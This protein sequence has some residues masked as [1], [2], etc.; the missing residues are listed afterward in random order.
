MGTPLLAFCDAAFEGDRS[1]VAGLIENRLVELGEAV[2]RDVEVIPVDTVSS[3]GLRIYQRAM[4]FVLIVAAREL[5]PEAQLLID[6]SVTIGGFFCQVIGHDSFTP[7]EL[8]AIQQRMREIVAADEPIGRSQMPVEDAIAHFAA[9]GNDDKVRL[10]SGTEDCDIAVYSLRGMLDCF[11]GPMLPSTGRL[12]ECRLEDYPP[13]FILRADVE[14]HQLPLESHRDYPKLMG[15]FREYGRWLNILGIEDVGSMNQAIERGDA[16]R[17][18]LVSE[19]LHEKRISEIADAILEREEVRVVLI[20]GPSS[21]GKTTFARRLSVQLMVNSRRPLPLGLD[22][23]FVDREKTPR[24]PDGQYD[25]EALEAIDLALFNAQLQALLSGEAVSVPRFDFVEGRGVP[26]RT[27]QLSPEG[28]LLIEGIHGLNPR[29]VY[30]IPEA[31][32]FR[33]Y[34][35]ALTQLNLD[36][37]NR[38]ATTDNRLLRRMV[39]DEATRGISADETLRRWPS[40]RLGEERNIFPFQE[41]AD[42]MFNSAL[43]YEVAVLK[44]FAER[45]LYR[46]PRDVPQAVESQRLLSLLRWVRPCDPSL[47]PSNSLLREFI[48]GSVL[49]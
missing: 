32:V 45:L 49:H 29:L 42:V 41:N 40:V 25:F 44:P 3:E 5:F 31:C 9:Q 6:H 48:G 13:G 22:D 30:Q 10:F 11:H 18:I 15:V 28:L 20:A 23:Y 27:V 21:S 2:R 14:R 37:H 33:V 12:G 26:G 19:A 36:H 39:R 43:V 7:A 38:V 47:V 17:A 4:T 8:A 1:Q 34:V 24:G 46:V 35:S 16:A